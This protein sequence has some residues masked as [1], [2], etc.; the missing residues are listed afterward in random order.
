[1]PYRLSPTSLARLAGVHPALVAVVKR[2]ILQSRQDFLVL[3][4]LRSQARQDRLYA[5][6]RSTPGPVV[7]WTR[8]SRH[9]RQADGFG[10]AVDLVPW[11]VDW[12]DPG[13]FDAVA[14]A[15]FAAAKALGHSVRWGADWDGDGR[16]RERGESDSPHFEIVP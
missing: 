3:E 5:Q 2:A 4:G 15:M 1:M 11:P 12:T 9:Q 16:P 13:K 6:G 7:T 14:E 10:H 8:K